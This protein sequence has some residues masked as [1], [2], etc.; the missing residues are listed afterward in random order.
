MTKQHNEAEGTGSQ[1]ITAETGAKSNA[2]LDE[3][4][5]IGVC[6][7]AGR[8]SFASYFFPSAS[9]PPVFFLLSYAD[10]STYMVVR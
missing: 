6:I 10:I 8:G 5:L 4:K 3:A 2:F 7:C 9:E 1:L